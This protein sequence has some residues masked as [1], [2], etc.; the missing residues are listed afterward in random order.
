MGTLGAKALGTPLDYGI[1]IGYFIAI[2]AFGAFF[3][4]YIRTTKEFFLGGQ[5]FAW[6]FIS[7]SCVA[8]LVGSY[9]FIKYSSVGYLYGFSSTQSYIN[10]IFL[11]PIF[12][13]CWLPVIYFTRCLS[14]PE[15]LGKRF[16]TGTRVVGTVILLMYMI[17]YVGINL[18]TLGVAFH[19]LLGIPVFTGAI[20][21][22]VLVTIYVMAGGQTAVIWTDFIQCFILLLAGIGVFIVGIFFLQKYGGFWHLFPISHKYGLAYF[23]KPPDF[24]F[25]GIFWQDAIANSFAF[26]MMNQGIM[27][28]F[29]SGRSMHDCR[30]AA[31]L[32]ILLLIIIAA[33][34]TSGGGWIARG[35]V[36]AGI[37]PKGL[38]GKDA[39][40]KAANV[41]C[42]PGVFGF[43]LAAL[44]AALMST[45]DT[46]LVGI[47][48]VFVNDIWRLAVVKKASDR[49]YVLA[50]RM[51]CL[52]GAFLGIILVPIF[53]RFK[54]IYAA[55]GAF[56]AAITP[57]LVVALVLGCTWKRYTPKAAFWTLLGGIIAVFISMKYP[58]LIKPFAQ[59]VPASG[60]FFMRALFGLVVSGAIAVGVTLFTKPKAKEEI[61]GLVWGTHREA[62]RRFKGGE[63][64]E[65]EGK[66]VILYVKQAE[67][68]DETVSLPPEAM[69]IMQAD[70]GD[71][72]YIADS[73]W[74]AGA[75]RGTQ[76]KVGSVI[77]EEEDFDK[78]YVPKSV[79]KTGRLTEG[80]KTR[81][82]K[83]F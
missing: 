24:N 14:V 11:L 6:W 1:I 27:M 52:V 54:T 39:F 75:L 26:W 31:L 81:V 25:V 19:T 74:W 36:S 65:R 40:V 43:V 50:G 34:A 66:S 3:A 77:T 17:G 69:K 29:M 15:Y 44:T 48:A 67:G 41:I 61:T 5:R 30:K 82:N 32:N 42:R 72:V 71:L 9:S 51:I 68:K 28:R 53:M 16:D 83:V 37:L 79:M 13:F 7:F 76:S 18:Y 63:P 64:N 20:V 46:L 56:T 62:M 49:H 45:V 55:H 38:A 10:D 60:W 8:T 57:P 12:A 58:I 59:G 70:I 35:L 21:I 80:E 78:V 4:R 47:S 73:R 33:V 23:N 22:A 2:T